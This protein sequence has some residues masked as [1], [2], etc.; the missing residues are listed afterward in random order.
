MKIYSRTNL[1][2]RIVKDAVR[3]T[4]EKSVSYISRGQVEVL[5][6]SNQL[7]AVMLPG[8]P[9]IQVQLEKYCAMV[10]LLEPNQWYWNMRTGEESNVFFI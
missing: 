10:T 7:Y 6:A 8:Y 1:P 4:T 9:K 5:D 2:E 3:L